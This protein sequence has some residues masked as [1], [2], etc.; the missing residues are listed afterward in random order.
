MSLSR[1]YAHASH[2]VMLAEVCTALGM[3]TILPP[4]G[5]RPEQ[6]RKHMLVWVPR[7]GGAGRLTAPFS[8]VDLPRL[9][10][11]LSLPSEVG[12]ELRTN[13]VAT[14]GVS[15]DGRYIDVRDI[16]RR[17]RAGQQVGLYEHATLVWQLPAVCHLP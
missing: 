13:I 4:G 3:P 8:Y 12:E 2:E 1:R 6:L 9:D 10:E 17:C 11:I 14:T 5:L 16:L 7:P 15:Y